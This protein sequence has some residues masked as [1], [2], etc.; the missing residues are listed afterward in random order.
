VRTYALAAV[1]AQCGLAVKLRDK[2]VRIGFDYDF[3]ASFVI[4]KY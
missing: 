3:I 2:L 4:A 1:R